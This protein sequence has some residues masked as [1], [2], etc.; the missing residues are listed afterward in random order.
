VKGAAGGRRLAL[1][2]PGYPPPVE[3]EVW[4]EL[5]WQAGQLLWADF[6]DRF[7]FRAGMSPKDLW[8][9][10]NPEPVVIW[11]STRLVRTR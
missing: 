5:D 7:R 2:L 11:S 6:A 9:F 1:G 3:E 10:Q 4:V 8:G